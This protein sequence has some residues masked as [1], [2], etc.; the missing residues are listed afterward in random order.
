MSWVAGQTKGT[1]DLLPNRIYWP[2]HASITGSEMAGKT[3][4]LGNLQMDN[5][6]FI[7]ATLVGDE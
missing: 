5:A 1:V 3:T 6:D 2:G 4:T 7:T